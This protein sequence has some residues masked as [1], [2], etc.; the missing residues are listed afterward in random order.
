LKIKKKTYRGEAMKRQKER[1][2]V[3][4]EI[5][6]SPD[7][8]IIY[9]K[10]KQGCHTLPKT[11]T[12]TL[13]VNI[14]NKSKSG[15][16]IQSPL[17]F[18]A[19]SS[20]D[21][22]IRDSERKVWIPVK[23]KVKWIKG[24]HPKRGYYP[25]GV[26]FDKQS[27]NM[28]IPRKA[29][30]DRQKRMI[31]PSDIDFFLNTKLFNAIPRESICP[32][33]NSLKFK[34]CKAGERFVSQGDKGDKLYIIR[35]GSCIV[36]LEKNNKLYPVARLKEGDVVGE[37]AVLTGERRSTHVDAET[38]MELW[39]LSRAEFD[40][41]S[42]KYPDLR[43][44]LTEIVTHRF[45]SS[46]LIASRTIGKYIIS[47]IIGR[48]GW[49]IVYKGIHGKLNLS[50]AI[51]MLKHNMAMD[52]DFMEKF[53]NEA[54]T[55]ARL[56]HP[57]I[58]K[59]YDIEE[60]FRTVFIVMEYLEGVSLEYI[61]ERMPKMTPQGILDI[62]LQVCSALAYAHQ[63]GIIHQDIKPANIYLQP[64]GSV[65]IVDFGL[66]CPPGNIDFG[67]PGTVYYMAPEQIQAD[68]VDE[69]TDVYSLGITAYE[70][71]TGKK[72]FMEDD[73]GK[74]MELHINEEIPDPRLSVPDLPV[75]LH[76]FLMKSTRKKPA[77]RYQNISEAVSELKPL[78]EKLGLKPHTQKTEKGKIMGLFLFYQDR[79]Q[80]AL[81]QLIDTFNNNVSKI[82]AVLRVTHVEGI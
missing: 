18:R 68:P 24:Y 16:L 70:M 4:R 34:F 50:V 21:L 82:G 77:E 39:S 81:N 41:L 30:Q 25:L 22:L 27:L 23:G 29:F 62:I 66:A 37:M 54:K 60:L 19:L 74:L 28:D 35:S 33:L 12:D 36:N 32:L 64:D 38:D 63:H 1:R 51:K 6:Q 9:L 44:F 20:L 40:V 2:H 48:G 5:L 31:T 52:P 10:S 15:V 46:K 69:R 49:S 79:H 14:L 3:P 8:G 73:I 42:Q 67:L 56:N 45:S 75:E 53:Q 11:G 17:R 47:D 7:F 76:R 26:E 61:L 13:L 43:I 65:K 78:A 72:P 55:I 57:G 71:I 58:V 59:V 80:L